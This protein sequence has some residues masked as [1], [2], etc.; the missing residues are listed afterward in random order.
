MV[1]HCVFPTNK[2]VLLYNYNVIIKWG[3]NIALLWY[4]NSQTPF[5]F[6][7]NNI[8][9]YRK[10]KSEFHVGSS[11]RIST[12]V[13]VQLLSLVWLYATQWTAA[14]QA[15]LSS[16][17]SWSLLRFMSIE[18]V[19]LANHLILCHPV[20]FSSCLQS[21]PASGFF[22]R[23]WLFAS[24]GQCIG[25]SASATVLPK[26]IQGWFLL[27]L[28]GLISLKSKGLSKVFSNTTVQKHQFFGTQLSLWSNTHIHTWL[29]EKP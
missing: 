9:L 6:C 1:F 4:P 18:L 5:K 27:G 21:S 3:T 23:S 25:A 10:S 14:C 12:V 13:V 19:M 28:T 24:G 2:N 26:H 15:P 29:L 8:L 17:V 22:P 20:P 7:P 11:C 16:S